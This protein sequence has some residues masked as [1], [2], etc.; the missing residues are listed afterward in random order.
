VNVINASELLLQAQGISRRN[1]ERFCSDTEART[2]ELFEGI[3]SDLR[4]H[5]ISLRFLELNGHWKEL[6]APKFL[7]LPEEHYHRLISRSRG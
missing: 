6:S 1:Y 5:G 3:K 7:V 2:T 4:R